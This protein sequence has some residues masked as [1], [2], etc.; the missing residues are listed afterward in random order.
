MS[1]PP[2]YAEIPISFG[3]EDARGVYFPHQDPFVIS[4]S[5]AYFEVRCI[6][7]DGGSLADLLFVDAFDM[8][9]IP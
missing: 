1:S 9:M 5:I 4:A 6:L 2:R 8:M 3:P 7:I